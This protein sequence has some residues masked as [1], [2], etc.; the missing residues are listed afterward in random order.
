MARLIEPGSGPAVERF[1]AAAKCQAMGV[2][3]RLKFK[4]IIPVRNWREE[5]AAAIEALFARVRPE[6]VGFCT[7]IWNNYEQMCDRLPVDLLDPS[8]VAAAR[9][10][11]DAMR[12]SRLGPF[13]HETRRDIYRFF[14][15]QVR[16]WD[17]DVPLYVSTESREMW[18][19]LKDE[20]GQDPQAYVCGCSSVA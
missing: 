14:I 19:E 10:A 9:D 15:Q 8:V 17:A 20:L 3:A 12:D 7:F 5:Y 16:R 11:Q 18:D 4:P 13:P 6:S 2:P 1:D